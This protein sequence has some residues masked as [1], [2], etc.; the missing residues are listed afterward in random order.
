MDFRQIYISSVITHKVNLNTK[1][2]QLEIEYSIKY[3][4]Y[5]QLTANQNFNSSAILSEYNAKRIM[6]KEAPQ[7]YSKTLVSQ[8]KTIVPAKNCCCR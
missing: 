2:L 4:Q 5:V 6:W 1:T 3:P 8:F 7:T